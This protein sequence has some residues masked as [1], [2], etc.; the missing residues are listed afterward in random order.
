MPLGRLEDGPV[1]HLRGRR[2]DSNM[3]SRDYGG[4]TIR[5]LD[6]PRPPMKQGRS[7]NHNFRGGNTNNYDPPSLLDSNIGPPNH[8]L[9]NDFGLN[10]RDQVS[11]ILYY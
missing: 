4:Q 1:M 2:Q 5:I 9:M 6:S 3:G 11:R 8:M 10:D 7:G